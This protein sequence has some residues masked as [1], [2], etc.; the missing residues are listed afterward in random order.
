MIKFLVYAVVYMLIARL[1]LQLARA[2]YY[3]SVAQWIIRLTRPVDILQR[4]IPNV[5]NINL[6]AIVAAYSVGLVFLYA[7]GVTDPKTLLLFPL[8]Q[9]IQLLCNFLI[10]LTLASVVI[11]W[12]AQGSDH[13]AVVIIRQA[14]EPLLGLIRSILPS[15]GGLDFSPVVVMFGLSFLKSGLDNLLFQLLA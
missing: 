15:F 3:N 11:S 1:W 13:D 5:A 10:Y 12:V 8:F 7:S 2:D 4:L 14:S 6:A 9:T